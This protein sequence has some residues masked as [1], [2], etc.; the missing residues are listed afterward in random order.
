[1]QIKKF[2]ISAI[3]ALLPLMLQAQSV[4]VV[5]SGGG[6]KGLS[7]IGVLKALEENHIPIDYIA[8]T[9]MGAIVGGLYSIGLTTDEMLT[10]FRSKEFESWYNGMQE[11]G[12]ATYFY[13][14]ETTA[15]MLGVTFSKDEKNKYSLNLP[16]SL[17]SPFPMDLAVMQLFASPAAASGYNFN[18]LMVP[19]R[20]VAADI[21]NK[22]PV[23]IRRGDMGSAIRASMTFP[24]FFKPIM[25]DS[26]LLFDGGFYNNFPW[27]VM[28]ED[29]NP[30]YI[31]GVKCAGKYPELESD[32]LLSQIE[33][34]LTV[35]TNYNLPETKGIL[36]DSKFEAINLLDFN[37]I[38]KLVEAGY[39]NALKY[40]PAIKAKIKREES[41][42]NLLKKR[43]AFRTRC[44]PLSFENVIISDSLRQSQKEFIDRTF[45]ENRKRYFDFEQLKRGY[46]R[47]IAS[48]NVKNFYP[49][50]RLTK[51]SVFDIHLRV[52]SAP[53]LRLS[54]G[55]N[56]SSSSL[57]QGFIG[58]E[59]RKFSSNPWKAAVDIN[60]GRFY[61]GL[62]AYWRQDFSIRPLAFYELQFTLHRFDYFG[63]SQTQFFTNRVLS[64]NVQES[65]MFAKFSIATPVNLY[66]NLLLK[67]SA[68]IGRTFY[69]YYQT[70]KFTTYDIPDETNF[71]F[72]SPSIY[73]ER[74]T[75]NYKIYPTVGDKEKVTLRYT[76]LTED[77]TPGSTSLGATPLKN[78]VH[79]TFSLRLYKESYSEISKNFTLGWLTD[80]TI[81]NR[82]AMGDRISTLLFLPAFQP[83]PH[84]RTLLLN[85]NR[86][87]SFMGIALMP[88][89]RF[90]KNLSLHLTGAYFQP[91]KQLM[92]TT[93]GSTQFTGLFP[94]GAFSADIAAVWQSPVGPVTLSASYY[95]KADVKWFPQLNIGFL[96][97][98]PKALSY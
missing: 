50:A 44:I 78:V 26:V 34:M 54:I 85:E 77:Y 79:G 97:Y 16:T 95:E 29:F 55:G 37:K 56:I 91:Y 53:S 39:Q 10:L 18:N 62:N 87:P 20:C 30:A 9:S 6:A 11:Q 86:A 98:K 35:E 7:H 45:R 24:F 68:D 71:T 15:E 80:I 57:N 88:I 14:R 33:N 61:S 21:A 19:F 89:V 22:K 17:I 12:F 49:V 2:V 27:D 40:I 48:G 51:D 8:G 66:K 96:V 38:D 42:A 64:S 28:L 70:D 65:E 47:V 69:E 59:Y 25:V 52:S 13:R 5:L 76:Y 73:L 31:I 84:S 1:M 93:D 3:V 67:V 23:T 92:V 75:T 46:Y 72:F 94:R 41:D 58:A 90:T 36:I 4:G 83:N 74:N 82:T 63:G 32:N 43:L 60:L 81:T